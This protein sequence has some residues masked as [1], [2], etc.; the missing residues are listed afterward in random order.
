MYN[1]IMTS[2]ERLIQSAGELLWERGYV[3]TSP[4]AIQQRSGAGQG[5]MYHHFSGK[6]ELA[7]EAIRRSAEELRAQ[8][9]AMLAG[10]GTATDRISR[11]LLRERDALRGCRLGRLAQDPE[12]IASP[13]LRQPLDEAFDWLRIRLA[14]V[15]TEGQVEGELDPDLDV[16]DTA[17]TLAAVL[18][19]GY[20]L[21][22]A[23]DSDD[24]FRRSIRGALGML[25]HCARG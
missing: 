6:M 23:A 8:A 1:S 4:R 22:R 16:T 24:P 20:V 19:G 9:E 18:Q 17:T 5:S 15:L 3:G 21:A 2:R 12:I 25:A 7:Q 10:P 13:E 11:Y 14:A